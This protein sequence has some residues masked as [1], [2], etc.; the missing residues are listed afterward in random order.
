MNSPIGLI[1]A[2]SSVPRYEGSCVFALTDR[3]SSSPASRA[4]CCKA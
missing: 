1:E 3:V 2:L 4:A